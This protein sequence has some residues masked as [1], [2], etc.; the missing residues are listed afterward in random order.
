M[1]RVIDYSSDSKWT[2]YDERP[3]I[4]AVIYKGGQGKRT[5]VPRLKP[6]WLRDT[7]LPYGIYWVYDP[8]YKPE[9]HVQAVLKYPELGEMGLYVDLEPPVI[10][11]T[12][13]QFHRLPYSD[14]SYVVRFYELM[15]KELGYVPHTYTSPGMFKMV[16]GV[17]QSDATRYLACGKLWTAQYKMRK[18]DLYGSWESWF[19]WQYRREPDFSVMD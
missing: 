6:Q 19:M 13:K 2:Y 7:D 9:A 18:P 4:D 17:A 12:E 5:D 10:G 1:K 8:R 11:M 14:Q 15:E 16:F 3:G